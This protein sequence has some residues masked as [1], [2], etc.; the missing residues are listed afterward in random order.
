MW[1]VNDYLFKYLLL[2]AKIPKYR[3]LSDIVPPPA[4]IP[5]LCIDDILFYIF[6]GILSI[7][8]LTPYRV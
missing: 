1:F 8:D 7:Q 3:I 6:I 4:I 5:L 2:M